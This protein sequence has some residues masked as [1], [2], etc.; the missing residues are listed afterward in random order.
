MLGYILSSHFFYLSVIFLQ[1]KNLLEE[2]PNLPESCDRSQI[3]TESAS[4][5]VSVTLSLDIII[6]VRTFTCS[7]VHFDGLHTWSKFQYSANKMETT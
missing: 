5:S 2:S 4:C 6:S 3:N 7:I 1:Y